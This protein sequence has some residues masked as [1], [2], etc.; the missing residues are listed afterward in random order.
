[1][2]PVV[3]TGATI[4]CMHGGQVTLLPKQTQVT[5]AGN[6]VLREGDLSGAPIIGCLQPPSPGTKPCT[7]VVSTLPGSASL[8]VMA[9]GAPVLL[10][11]LS[12]IT[13]G[14]PPGTIMVVSPGQTTVQ[15]N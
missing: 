3:T 11:T 9:A 5:I 7:M 13:D 14:V 1:M 4:L 6:P 12:G 2:P 10:A 15:A 8:R